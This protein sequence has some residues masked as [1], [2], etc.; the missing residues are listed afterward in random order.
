MKILREKNMID[1]FT[2]WKKMHLHEIYIIKG[3]I[4]LFYIITHRYFLCKIM[5]ILHEVLDNY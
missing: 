4:G 5:Y 3:A 2:S 1:L